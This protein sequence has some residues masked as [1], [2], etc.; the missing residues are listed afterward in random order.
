LEVH[1]ASIAAGII[2][3][4]AGHPELQGR[5]IRV[6]RMKVGKLSTVVPENLRFM[7]EAIARG[8]PLE[9]V[10]LEIDEVPARATCEACGE[11]FEIDGPFFLCPGCGEGRIRVES[12]RELLVDSVDVD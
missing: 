9:G 12:G 4:L 11:A 6:V 2:D 3:R 7:F 5:R 1:E 10:A 8:T